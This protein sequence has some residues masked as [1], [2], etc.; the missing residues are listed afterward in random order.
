[1]GDKIISKYLNQSRSLVVLILWISMSI[2]LMF[3]FASSY[4]LKIPSY[5]SNKILESIFDN[6]HKIKISNASIIDFNKIKIEDI[7]WDYN[8]SKIVAKDIELKVRYKP[9]LFQNIIEVIVGDIT[10]ENN[11][12]LLNAKN[13]KIKYSSK[14]FFGLTKISIG[15]KNI[16]ANIFI[17]TNNMQSGTGIQNLNLSRLFDYY[18]NS[19]QFFSDSNFYLHGHISDKIELHLST[20]EKQAKQSNSIAHVIYQSTPS[21]NKL[22]SLQLNSKKNKFSTSRFDVEST[23]LSINFNAYFNQRYNLQKINRADLS[24]NSINLHGPLS[25]EIP[26]ILLSAYSDNENGISV[27]IFSDSNAQK[28]SLLINK[29]ETPNLSGF[30]KLTPS[31]VQLFADMSYGKTKVIDGEHFN[32]IFHGDYELAG[33]KSISNFNLWADEFSALETPPGNF[34]FSGKINSDFS[35]FID[36]AY[37][38]FGASKAF[39]RYEQ[40][41]NPLSYKFT[42][43][44][45]CLPSDI[46]PWLGLWW[47]KIWEDFS[48]GDESPY[49]KFSISG[50]WG[51]HPENF[52]TNGIVKGKNISYRDLKFSDSI[53]NVSVQNSF[54]TVNC[55]KLSHD[56]GDLSGTLLFSPK[57]NS[58]RNLKF[59]VKGRYPF[60]EGRSI[61][62]SNTQNILRDINAS[63]VDVEGNG[64]IFYD[65]L[66]QTS[67]Q[68]HSKFTLNLKSIEETYYRNFPI[69]SFSGNVSRENGLIRLDFPI[70]SVAGGKGAISVNEIS[71]LTKLANVNLKLESASFSEISNLFESSSYL[72]QNTENRA[73]NT[74][75]K[76]KGKINLY[77][78]GTG[79]SDNY[80][81]FVGTGTVSLNEIDV[82][83]INILGGIRKNLGRFNLPLPSDALRFDSLNIPFRIENESVLFDDFELKGPVSRISGAGKCEINTQAVEISA[84]LELLGGVNIP[85]IKQIISLADPISKLTQIK[86]SGLISNPDWEIQITPMKQV[87]E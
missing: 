54:T 21:K 72:P 11:K 63:V 50:I 78:S 87:K 43:E 60:N 86:I 36:N 3:L 32:L 47:S 84:D 48:F 44:G 18:R 76:S 61:F 8:S 73:D 4:E 67:D 81:Q 37:G 28:I 23:D 66:S 41:W 55:E 12:T 45:N 27:N 30:L 16:C 19:I 15:E 25:G 24:F 40:H 71:K 77:F 65:K 6:H 49:G 74:S 29:N 80:N 1:M 69:K 59:E 14:D 57:R 83:S 31:K 5:I 9:R 34:I 58:N 42:L 64:I 39:G 33:K 75:L 70:L 22:I 82:G 52:V 35:I 53:L 85:V 56:K 17:D 10:I 46:D 20:S 26:Q 7:K 38:K 13:S 62:D 79:P 51:G 68:N 2:Q